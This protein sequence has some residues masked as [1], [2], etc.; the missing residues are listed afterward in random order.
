MAG[1]IRFGVIGA[2][3][4]A[5]E[6]SLRYLNENNS[7]EVIGIIDVNLEAAQSLAEDVSYRRAGA[8]IIGSKYRETVD[9]TSIN[10]SE[11]NLPQVI[12]STLL[13][14][15]LPFVDCVYIATPPSTHAILV[16]QVLAAQK[17]ILLEKPLAVG[18][19]D[20]D[21]IVRLAEEA[22]SNH[23]LIV[24]LNIGMRYN[25]AL[26]E[27][28][29]LIFDSSSFGSIESVSLRLLF[30][31]W[32]REWQKQPWVAQRFEG[33][34][35]L[36]VGTHWMF[37]ILELFGQNNYI[38]SSSRIEY[39]D[40]PNG[41]LC[42]SSCVGSLLFQLESQNITINIDI[43]TT[44][45]EASHLGKDIYELIVQGSSGKRYVLYDFTRLREDI[46]T[47]TNENNN[48][49][50]TFTSVDL[51]TNATYGRNE[52]V[53]DCTDWILKKKEN[54]HYV[55]PEEARNAQRIIETMKEIKE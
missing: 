49:N 2:G 18:L 16:A 35:L 24:S 45:E 42:E 41:I 22:L 43:Q 34:P 53:V 40:G 25:S 12:S 33:G 46:L 15:L 10:I 39:P 31:Q 38:S 19:D 37:G 51:V 3:S 54:I 23:N 21:N 29:R 44:N 50:S 17:H 26:H 20:C 36:E 14:D 9:K 27:M 4:I 11:T 13:D 52:C 48:I 55:T 6:F 7:A 1:K 28:R 8:K 47:R 30:R 5:R 32:P